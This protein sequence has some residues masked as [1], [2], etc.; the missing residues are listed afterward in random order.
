MLTFSNKYSEE[1]MEEI[2]ALFKYANEGILV[3]NEKGKIV[4]ANPSI[5]KLFG[6]DADELLGEPVEILIPTELAAK[7][8]KHV[9]GFNENPHAR[10]MGSNMQLAARKKD[11]SSF[12]VEVSL[13]PY[14][15][16]NGKFIIAFIIDISV[17]KIAEDKAKNYSNELENQV[18]KR[19]MILEEAINE[20]EKTKIEL[21]NALEKERVLN[22]M[23]SRF[24]SMASHEFRTPLATILSSL[25]LVKK[26]GELK[27]DEKQA[28]HINKIKLSINNL[29]DILNDVLSVSKLDEGKISYSPEEFELEEF[30]KETVTDL[31]GLT[32][33][34]QKIIY[35]HKGKSLV[36]LDKKVLRHVLFNL[37]SN[38]IKFSEENKKISVS[39]SLQNKNLELLVSDEGMGIPKAD[40]EHLFERF[41]RG[42]NVTNIQGTGLGLNIVGK[43]TELMNGTIDF[44][45]V[46]NKGTTFILKFKL[47]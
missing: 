18:K 29:T 13:S 27:E 35:Q 2:E 43:Y 3:V 46:E 22:E 45:S 10:S 8:K 28:T 19:T 20:L 40:Q 4:R 42:R 14:S 15:T 9:K 12:P 1:K 41:F 31:Q 16:S 25:S 38:A 5:E 6:Y 24:V 36:W 33:S 7:H 34:E 21:H 17:R 44:K 37:V 11:G 47:Q 30:V 32:K 23:K 26:Y 39:T